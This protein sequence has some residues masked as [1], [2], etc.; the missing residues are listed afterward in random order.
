MFVV[1]TVWTCLSI[2]VIPHIEI[3]L[4]QEL[5]MSPSSHVSKYFKVNTFYILDIQ[6]QNVSFSRDRR[7]WM[8]YCWW[9]HPCTG[10][11]EKG[12][13]LTTSRN[14]TWFA[15]D[16]AAIITLSWPV[17][18]CLRSTKICTLNFFLPFMISPHLSFFQTPYAIQNERSDSVI[19]VDWWLYRL[20]IH[21]LMLQETPRNRGVLPK[22][23]YEWWSPS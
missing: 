19:I 7:R 16:L 20:A 23:Q 2:Y 17:Y 15:V 3:G 11:L 8:N 21:W 10:S 1:F 9:D 13:R 12:Y 6:S 5:T 18:T 4:D 14:R 22:Q